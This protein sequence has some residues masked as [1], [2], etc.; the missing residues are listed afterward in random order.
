V[1]DYSALRRNEL[2]NHEKTYRNFKYLELN[3]SQSEKS[4]IPTMCHS[5]KGK[6]KEE[7]KR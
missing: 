3:E 1:G 6:T 2:S 4:V 5:G 7:V